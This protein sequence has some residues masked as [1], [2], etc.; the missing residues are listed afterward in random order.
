[1]KDRYI[2]SKLKNLKEETNQLKIKQDLLDV[3][4]GLGAAACI[5]LAVVSVFSFPTF[6]LSSA[7]GATTCLLGRRKN[8]KITNSKLDRLEKETNHLE[9]IKTKTPE[10]TTKLNKKRINKLKALKDTI[11]NTKESYNATAAL[12]V[13]SDIAIVTGM[14]T[15]FINPLYSLI[16]IG[17]LAANAIIGHNLINKNKELNSLQNRYNNIENDLETIINEDKDLDK[18]RIKSRHGIVTEN[19]NTKEKTNTNTNQQSRPLPQTQYDKN[20]K[21]ADMFINNLA[22]QNTN[23]KPVQKVKK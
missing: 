6:A 8:K 20:T 3:I 1:M 15:T 23:S 12:N 13:L 19:I 11:K 14:I 22:N 4:T 7:I 18:N 9:K 10:K 5:T 21:I 17:G 2:N 16:G